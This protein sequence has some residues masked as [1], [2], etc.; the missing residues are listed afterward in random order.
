[1]S[2][3]FGICKLITSCGTYRILKYALKKKTSAKVK[4]RKKNTPTNK[5]NPCEKNFPEK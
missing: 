1:M 4:K 2:L 5:K 3:W